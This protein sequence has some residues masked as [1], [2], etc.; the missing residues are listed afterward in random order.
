[1][2]GSERS[3]VGAMWIVV[4]KEGAFG[5]ALVVRC[6]DFGSANA[7]YPRPG[8]FLGAIPEVQLRFKI[9]GVE[10]DSA[11]EGEGR[12]G[13]RSCGRRLLAKNPCK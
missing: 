9:V 1:M 12:L 3:L 5:K 11:L 6:V 7:P 4:E 2:C 8:C 13:G 10:C